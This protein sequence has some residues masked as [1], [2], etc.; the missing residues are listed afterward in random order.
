[1]HADGRVAEL[2]LVGRADTAHADDGCRL[3]VDGGDVHVGDHLGH[4]TD[5]LHTFPIQGVLIEHRDCQGRL[6]Q[7]GLHPGG[8]HLHRLQQA[9]LRHPLFG[10]GLGRS[11]LFLG[12][13][14]ARV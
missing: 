7:V 11:L 14:L 1:M 5:V 3:A 4:V 12:R 6:H 10:I 2:G 8:G 13:L 9:F